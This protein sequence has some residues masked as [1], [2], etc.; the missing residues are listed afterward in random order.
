ML[1]MTLSVAITLLCVMLTKPS[2]AIHFIC[3]NYSQLYLRRK[4]SHS[5]SHR[6]RNLE[7]Q[8][9]IQLFTKRAFLEML[10]HEPSLPEARMITL[11]TGVL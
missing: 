9:Q 7:L 8:R 10:V 2:T 6:K 3:L 5:Q 11:Q 1:Q 4:H